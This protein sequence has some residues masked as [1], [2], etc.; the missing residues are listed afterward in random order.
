MESEYFR[1][2]HLV[3][4]LHR[5]SAHQNTCLR[6]RCKEKYCWFYEGHWNYS[7]SNNLLDFRFFFNLLD[8][9]T[10]LPPI[11]GSKSEVQ[12]ALS[13]NFILK[14]WTLALIVY[15]RNIS[16][17]ILKKLYLHLMFMLRIFRFRFTLFWIGIN[18]RCNGCNGCNV[19]LV[20][21]IDAF[22]T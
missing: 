12:K 6:I 13:K 11:D 10:I 5:K 19:V 16:A 3:H 20:I 7:V 18:N 22:F 8:A 9:N 4:K 15:I 1:S 17:H 2:T 14:S 21:R